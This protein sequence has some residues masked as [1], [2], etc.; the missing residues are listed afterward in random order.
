MADDLLSTLLLAVTTPVY[1]APAMNTEMW[2]K[3]QVQRNIEYLK[4]TGLYHFIE[5]GTGYLSCQV[6]GPGRMAEPVEILKV[7]HDFFDKH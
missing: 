5:P 1:F 6:T 7:V 4:S 3:P 2:Q